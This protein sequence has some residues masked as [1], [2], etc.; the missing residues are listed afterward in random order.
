MS[1]GAGEEGRGQEGSTVEEGVQ[2]LRGWVAHAGLGHH[3]LLW[4]FVDGVLLPAHIRSWLEGWP[5][6]F[7]ELLKDQITY[8]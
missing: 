7:Y 5:R 4:C 1:K 6:C 2:S 3:D 8:N